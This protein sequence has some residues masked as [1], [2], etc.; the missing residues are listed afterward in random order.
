MK[1]KNVR[2][3]LLIVTQVWGVASYLQ[4]KIVILLKNED[5]SITASVHYITYDGAVPDSRLNSGLVRFIK[6]SP[7]SP[8]ICILLIKFYHI[9]DS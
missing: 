5:S 7:T 2:P 8:H 9:Q 6:K 3:F 4:K 1:S